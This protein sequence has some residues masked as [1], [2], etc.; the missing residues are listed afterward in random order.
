MK[1]TLIALALAAFVVPTAAAQTAPTDEAAVRQVVVDV[2][3]AMRARDTVALRALFHPTARLQRASPN[4]Q[5]VVT[6][7]A[8]PIDRFIQSIGGAT[9]YL[10][11]QIWDVEIRVDRDLATVWNKYAMFIDRQFSHCGVDAFQLG[12]TAEGWKIFQIADTMER[13]RSACEMPPDDG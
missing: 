5:G 3:D 9:V 12:R 8:L 7:E 2:F 4:R 11:E 6:L 13:D 10:D 1:R